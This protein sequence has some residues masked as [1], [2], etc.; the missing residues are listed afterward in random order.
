MKLNFIL[1]AK[2]SQEREFFAE[3]QGGGV[4]VAF[5]SLERTD[6]SYLED[7]EWHIY[8]VPFSFGKENEGL[9]EGVP[10]AN[11]GQ[12]DDSAEPG[13]RGVAEVEVEVEDVEMVE[14]V[15]TSE[16]E[17]PSETEEVTYLVRM[18]RARFT[19]WLIEVIKPR[20]NC[21][22]FSDDRLFAN[23]LT[24]FSIENIA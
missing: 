24:E 12:Q 23:D 10:A 21:S 14:E 11:A 3:M 13:R 16:D 6:N 8:Y 19:I 4:R 5:R 22:L 17:A 18:L 9:E 15:D 1:C 7:W 20:F 2:V